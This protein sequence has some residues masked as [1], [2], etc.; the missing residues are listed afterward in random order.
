MVAVLLL[1]AFGNLLNPGAPSASASEQ[2]PSAEP[3]DAATPSLSP[4]NAPATGWTPAEIAGVPWVDGIAE[5]DGRL[6]AVGRTGIQTGRVVIAYSDD[7]E[8]WT[9]VDMPQLGLGE[10]EPQG[11]NM[12]GLMSLGITRASPDSSPSGRALPRTSR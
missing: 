3:T 11:P 7:G 2:S 8:T 9:T 1:I 5:R 4:T 10:I 12:I 6:V